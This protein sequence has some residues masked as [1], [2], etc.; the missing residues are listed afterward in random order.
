MFKQ[1]LV[2][3]YNGILISNEKEWALGIYKLDDSPGNYAK[4]RKANP[5]CTKRAP[6]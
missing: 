4:L 2:H 6:G 5:I 3:S 1:T